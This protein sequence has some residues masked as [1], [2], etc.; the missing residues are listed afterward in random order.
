MLVVAKDKVPKREKVSFTVE[1]I[2]WI[3]HERTRVFRLTTPKFTWGPPQ[4]SVGPIF[5]L[6]KPKY[7]FL[8]IPET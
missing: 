2:D 3:S 4:G 5:L 6:I 7:L 8:D 1:L